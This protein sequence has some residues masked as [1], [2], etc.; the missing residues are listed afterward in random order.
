MENVASLDITANG[1]IQVYTQYSRLYFYPSPHLTPEFVELSNI[2]I[3][4]HRELKKQGRISSV[5][6][7]EYETRLLEG[8]KHW[9]GKTWK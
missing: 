5:L 6:N 2:F 1:R 8:I 3:Q 9:D 7:P 4:K